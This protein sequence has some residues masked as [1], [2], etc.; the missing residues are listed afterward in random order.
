VIEVRGVRRGVD[1]G[2]QGEMSMP[3]RFDGGV[4]LAAIGAVLLFVSLFLDWFEP[5][6]SAWTVFELNDLVLAALALATLFVAAL[7]LFAQDPRPHLPTGSI[8]YAGA[9]AMIIVAGT[10]IQHPP[11]A[12]HSSP[13]VGAW[14]ALVGAA[15]IVAGGILQRARISIVVT[16]RAG[17]ESG[18]RP[19]ATPPPEPAV[20]S[21]PPF[22]DRGLESDR[23]E[24]RP[25]RDDR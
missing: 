18:R 17:R 6:R 23:A 19:G 3:E 25:L 10:L 14:L 9:G 2:D 12:L 24:T 4:A 1:P 16:R 7:T 21:P 13:Q 22:E 11:S 5:G 20:E 8:P 15:T